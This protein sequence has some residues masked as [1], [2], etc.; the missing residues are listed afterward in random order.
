MHYSISEKVQ[1]FQAELEEK[2]AL[3]RRYHD[4]IESA[5]AAAT[6]ASAKREDQ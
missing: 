2:T 4:Q 1:N 6:I 5:I 3:L